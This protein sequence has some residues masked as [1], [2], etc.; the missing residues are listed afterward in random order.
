M[1]EQ[2]KK[3]RTTL[4]IEIATLE[5]K[6]TKAS[7]S[8]LGPLET[9]TNREKLADAKEQL[10][11][12]Q[13]QLKISADKEADKELSDINLPI[14]AQATEIRTR[15][16]DARLWLQY[17]CT[18]HQV[19][20]HNGGMLYD[21]TIEKHLSFT[22]LAL[23][24]Y[25]KD[26]DTYNEIAKE[27]YL[28]KVDALRP[29]YFRA[30]LQLMYRDIKRAHLNQLID[31]IKFDSTINDSELLKWIKLTTGS[32][33]VMHVAVIKHVM[34][35]VKRK[36]L[37]LPVENHIFPILVGSQGDG[38]T[39]ALQ[40]LT[41]A[42]SDFR[43]EF[44]VDQLSDSTI[45]GCF[46]DNFVVLCDEMA[47]AD[48]TDINILK[49]AV[50]SENL[51]GRPPYGHSVESVKQNCTFLGTSN[52]PIKRL[53]R[54][55]EMRRFVEVSTIPRLTE[56]YPV[57]DGLDSMLMWKCI[58]E[59][60]QNLYYNNAKAEIKLHQSDLSTSEPINIWAD[61]FDIISN[62]NNK[63]YVTILS[64]YE[65]WTYWMNQNGYEYKTNIN[66]FGEKLQELHLQNKRAIIGGRKVT[67]YKVNA[68]HT[69]MLNTDL[70]LDLFNSK[71]KKALYNE[72]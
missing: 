62:D 49:R 2:L 1:T 13:R 40:K 57:M 64:L 54:D 35:Q 27:N 47:K 4:Q 48:K 8:K 5:Q 39:K 7:I 24:E 17:F 33:N 68:A 37:G 72:N 28:D 23:L 21:G 31:K 61:E 43:L 12:V 18:K 29:D 38:K 58:D 66:S 63:V 41:E 16:R 15:L 32:L 59:N 6:L 3:E 52:V 44:T 65:Q 51:S 26:V 50:T 36:M 42:I 46:E 19:T 69:L 56:D 53:I 22:S 45:I 9:A 34:Q 10:K 55:N 20:T 14:K 67:L 60:A 70:E 71:E 30:G 25:V 11:R